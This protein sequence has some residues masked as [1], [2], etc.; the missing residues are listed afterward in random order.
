MNETKKALLEVRDLSVVFASAGRWRKPVTAVNG[1]SFEIARGET[2]G[3]VGESGSGKSTIARAVLGLVRPSAGQMLFEGQDITYA[4][5]RQRRKVAADLSVVF[6]DPYSSLNPALSIGTILA[7]PLIAQKVN[8]DTARERIGKLIADVGLPPDSIHRFPRQFS[9]GQRQRIA[10]AR[11]LAV[12]PSLIICD[13][14][15][16]ALDLSIQAQIVNLLADIRDE[17][18]L[19]MLF[20]AHDL[21]IVRHVAHRTAVVFHGS[22]MEVGPAEQ[23]YG[24]PLHPYSVALSAAA[25]VPDPKLQRERRRARSGL[26]RTPAQQTPTATTGCPFWSRCPERMSKCE[27]VRPTLVR[28]TNE[29]SVACHLYGEK[30]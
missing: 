16:S 5:H 24:N 20:V 28:A 6:Q 18:G 10:I 17:F 23:I 1:V 30:V 25:L 12:E 15:V 27:T 7:E 29:T 11:A 3:I 2:L 19:A 4:G 21:S 14:P 26:S 13:E 8:R 9:G 22:V